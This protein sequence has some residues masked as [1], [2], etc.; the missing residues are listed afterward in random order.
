MEISAI[1]NE[2]DSLDQQIRSISA[3]MNDSEASY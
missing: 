1:Y 3:S 2:K